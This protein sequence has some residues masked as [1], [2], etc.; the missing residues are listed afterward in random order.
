MKPPGTQWSWTLSGYF[1]QEET[2][3]ACA[4]IA[5]EAFVSGIEAY[6]DQFEDLATPELEPLADLYAEQG[7]VLHSY[8]LPMRDQDDVAAFYETDRRAAVDTI[9]RHMERAAMLGAA[10]VVLHPTTSRHA[11]ELEGFEAFLRPLARSLEAL[12]DSADTLGIDLLLENMMPAWGGTRFASQPE[13]F[14]RFATEFIHPRL[15]FCFDTGHALAACGPARFPELLHTMSSGLGACHLSDTA[16]DRDAHLAPGRGRVDWSSFFHALRQSS[17]R[18]LLCIETPPFAAGPPYAVADWRQLVA[19]CQQLAEAC[20][21]P[22][23][24]AS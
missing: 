17:P 16:G 21:L 23:P 7:I 9:Q 24:L 22:M 2:H 20:F 8:H 14:Q 13:H 6:C 4:R 11:V 3:A 10:S 12:L 19:D 1:L 15:G 5:R 18:A